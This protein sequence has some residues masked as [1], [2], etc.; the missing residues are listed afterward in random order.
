VRIRR[1]EFVIVV[2]R[3]PVRKKEGALPVAI[4][5]LERWLKL[6]FSYQDVDYALEREE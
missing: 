4:A 2:F 5:T 6:V 3:P 1:I